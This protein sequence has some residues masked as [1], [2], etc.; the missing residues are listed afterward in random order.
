VNIT[1]DCVSQR[2]VARFLE[3]GLMDPHIEGLSNFYRPYLQKMLDELEKHMPSTV[4]WTK[5]EGG[6]FIWLTLP[7]DVNA[8][9][10]FLLAKEQKVSFIPGSKFYPTGQEQYNTLRLNFT[11]STLEQIET[12]I[13][14][15]ARLFA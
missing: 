14:R 6:I 5:P 12:G 4:T 9:D 1:P 8:D 10:L 2:V 15:L 7:E 11:F 3:K 13:E